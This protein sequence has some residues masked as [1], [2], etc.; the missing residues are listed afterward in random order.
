MTSLW[1][2]TE[3][4]ADGDTFT[5]QGMFDDVVVGAGLTGLTTALLLTRAG[6]RVAIVEA[7]SLGAVTTGNTT[8]K[9]S[10][11]QGTQLSSILKNHS[12]A[13]AR[14]YLDGNREGQAWLLHYCGE[15]AVPV[16]IRDA[17]SY[18]GTTDG[19]T[20]ARDE[21][22][23]CHRV[24]LDV[25]WQS[26][27]DLPF[28][29]F[30]AIRLTDQAQIDPIQLLKAMAKDFRTRGGRL[31]EGVRVLDIDTGD[32]CLVKTDAGAVRATNVILA[33]GTPILDRGL[34][35]AKLTAKRS[36]ALAFRVPATIPQGMYLSVD[37]PTR[38]LRTAARDGAE[39]LLVGG[40]G[41]DVGREPS[42]KSRVAD[43]ISWTERHFPGAELTHSWSAQDY[44]SHNAAPFVGKL[45]RGAGHV[46]VATGYGKWGMTNGVAAGLRLA[47]EI[48][49]G[50]MEWA[51]T[52]GKRL[53]YPHGVLQGLQANAEVA[54]EMVRGWATS[55]VHR[56]SDADEH[57]AEGEGVVRGVGVQPVGICTVDGATHK[58]SAVCSH[59]K[60]IVTWNDAERS[61]DCP[62]HGSRYAADGALLE[63]PATTGLNPAV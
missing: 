1:L 2:D 47:A 10:L 38:S 28:D 39:L 6:H 51:D 50:H 15:R 3:P 24:G 44:V 9:V 43:L 5:P 7:R 26:H 14:A 34:Y 55:E 4:F 45:P 23:A 63:G 20:A 52:L 22:E 48:L 30:G 32:P 8:G 27:A 56:M 36:Y 25:S 21:F 58:V 57:P 60:G 29:T 13:V 59:L 40:N 62:L 53:T 16:E 42:P 12:E 11:L 61:W 49:G 54:V 33:T 31:Y 46:F 37:E 35:F 41:H 18:A 17:Y 19:R